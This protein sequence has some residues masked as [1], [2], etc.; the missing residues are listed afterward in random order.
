MSPSNMNVKNQQPALFSID[1]L[2]FTVWEKMSEAMVCMEFLGL[3]TEPVYTGH[4]A[5]GF[6][7][8]YQGVNGEVVYAIPTDSEQVYTHFNLP[9][10]AIQRVTPQQLV[11]LVNYLKSS[12]WRWKIT[13]LDLAF[14]TQYFDNDKIW[15]LIEKDKFKSYVNR[16]NIERRK[17]VVESADTINIGARSSTQF[18]RIYLKRISEHPIFG[19]EDFTRFELE[20]HDERSQ[21]AILYLAAS[22]LDEWWSIGISHLR[23]FIDFQVQWW[24]RW[25][26]G[27]R[28]FRLKLERKEPSIERAQ[29]WL[30]TQVYPTLAAVALARSPHVVDDDGV[31][32]ATPEQVA[33]RMVMD[34][35]ARLKPDH[36][37]MIKQYNPKIVQ[38]IAVFDKVE[39]FKNEAQQ[40]PARKPSARTQKELDRWA[41][42]RRV[43][44]ASV[45]A[46]VAKHH[47][48][49][50]NACNEVWQQMVKVEYY[51]LRML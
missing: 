48:E 14:D 47:A 25:C 21:G 18:A 7:M 42:R 20:L 34:G 35:K 33:A 39:R 10:Q 31:I 24:D 16:E 37:K 6:K 2:R 36:I 5:N 23:G 32:G 30:E 51:R 26:K 11:D 29:Q 50:K 19:D 4:G 41:A 1:Y 45:P 8:L 46:D 44:A 12:G 40:T 38:S 43:S 15:K 17:N 13:R 3:D 9:G 49:I 22:P 28:P 27:V